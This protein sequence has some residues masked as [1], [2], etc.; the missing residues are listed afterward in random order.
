MNKIIASAPIVVSAALLAIFTITMSSNAG[1]SFGNSAE[2]VYISTSNGSTPSGPTMHSDVDSTPIAAI[3]TISNGPQGNTVYNPETTTIRTG[4]EILVLNNSS[5][6]HSVTNGNGPS[7]PLA[8][9]LFDTGVIK[10]GGF[11]E[12]VASNLQ[13]GNYPYYSSSDPSVKGQMIIT[14]NQQ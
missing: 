3:I 13:P 9:K 14:S 12:Y 1:I 2:I 7:D 10:P 11:I 4:E 5:S 8:G 6:P